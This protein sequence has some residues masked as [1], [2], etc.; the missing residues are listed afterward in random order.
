MPALGPNVPKPW[1]GVP[2]PNAAA[3]ATWHPRR[4]AARAG[5]AVAAVAAVAVIAVLASGL[6]LAHID[7]GPTAGWARSTGHDALWMGRIWAEGSYTR[8]DFDQLTGHLRD[9][10][11]SDVYVFAGQL[12]SR[13]QLGPAA[14]DRVRSF[15][16]AFHAALPRIRV[17]AWLSG[18]LGPGHLSLARPATRGAIV[19]TVA[20]LLRAGFSGLHYD[21]EPV[22]DGDQD[23]LRLLDATDALRQRPE[24][25]SVSVP[26]LEPLP[27]LRLPWQVAGVGPVFWT[28]GYL[29]Q[30]SS[31]VNQVALMAYDT[32]M[33][34]GSW[35][36]GYVARQAELALRAVPPRVRLL[37]GV[38]CYHYTNL[39]HEASAET[40]ASAVH[41][42]RVALTERRARGRDVGVALFADYSATAQDWRS[43]QSGWVRGWVR[44]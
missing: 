11:V 17:S 3:T 40:V 37:I 18:V 24:P 38:P 7:G 12:D 25:L 35:Y 21:L 23:Y 22:P 13:G 33:P 32:S 42:V 43:Y 30:V 31:R 44:P 4:L 16:A 8:A 10:G 14:Y 28:T 1:F 26:K 19:A 41:G 5:A 36:G 27:G 34:L 6:L 20:T 15:L 2:R 29:A 9:S 39:A